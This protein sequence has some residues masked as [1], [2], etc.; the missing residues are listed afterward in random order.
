MLMYAP[1]TIACRLSALSVST[2]ASCLAYQNGYENAAPTPR[3]R[4]PATTAFLED[5]PPPRGRC[6]L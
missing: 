5:M 4:A 1:R 3:M 2:G 6:A